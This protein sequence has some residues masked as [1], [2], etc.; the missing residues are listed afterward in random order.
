MPAIAEFFA[1]FADHVIVG[2]GW[3]HPRRDAQALF[4]F[5]EPR[6]H[7]RR[8]VALDVVFLGPVFQGRFRGAETGGPVDQRGA[9]HR[10]ALEDGDR[11]VLAHAADA[12]LIKAGVGLVFEQLEVAAGLERAFFDQQHFVAG[13]AEDFSRGST[14][15]TAADD[16]HVRFEGQVLAQL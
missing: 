1:A 12:F 16:R 2:V 5:F 15:G 7:F 14:A 13:C 8:A 6:R 10:P 11:A 9:A 3:H 4:H